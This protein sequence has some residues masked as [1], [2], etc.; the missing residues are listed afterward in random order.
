MPHAGATTEA[1][2]PMEFPNLWLL[3]DLCQHMNLELVILITTRS[4]AANLASWTLNRASSGGF[5]ALAKKQYQSA[6]RYLFGFIFRAQVPFFFLSLEAL[7]LDE[8]KY[9]QSIFQLLG[10]SE[11][12][13]ML[14][15]HPD[16]NQTRYKWYSKQGTKGDMTR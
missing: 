13:V 15:L 7:L 1:A 11:Y 3:Q 8:Q 16:V 6:Y 2:Q 12:P 14:D 9:I 5:I 4:T 10:L